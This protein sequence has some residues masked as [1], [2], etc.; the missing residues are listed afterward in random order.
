MGQR[1]SFGIAVTAGAEAAGVP[2]HAL[3]TDIDAICRARDALVPLAERLGVDPP[4]PGLAGLAYCHVS[5]LGCEVTISSESVEPWARPCI[6]DPAEIDELTEPDDYLAAGVVPDRLALAERLKAA[7]PDASTGIGHDYEGPVTTAA[8]MM[9]QDFFTLP[10]DDP[11]RAHRLME[12]ATRSAVNY[13]RTLRA[14][15][16][17]PVA[18][19]RQGICDDFAGMFGPEQFAEF[20]APYWEMMYQGLEAESRGMHSELLREE[21]MPFLAAA[22]IDEYDPSVDQYLTPE[23]LKRSCPVPYTLRMW[24]SEVRDHSADELV[25]MYRYRAS[26][27]PV[28]ISFALSCL[29]EEEK[30]AALLAVAREL[31]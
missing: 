24:P 12:F 4:R 30:A 18:G 7:R 19:G 22:A 1:Y 29:S 6:S 25:E 10:Y 13:A 15:Q 20:V 8:L 23:T 9:G 26:F 11:A 14:H 5:T 27:E 3:H 21:H 17:R 28:F 16:G 2:L 31:A